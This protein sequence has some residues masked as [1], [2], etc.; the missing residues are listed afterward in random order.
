M[1]WI[2]KRMRKNLNRTAF[3]VLVILLPFLGACVKLAL[4]LTP[5]FVP[6]LRETVFEECD[7][8]LAR[9]AIPA[10][11]KLMEGLLKNDPRNRELLVTL[12]MGF[13]GYAML[14]VEGEDQERA[15]L[16]YRRARDYGIRALGEKGEA[17]RNPEAPAKEVD[18]RLNTMGR[19]DLQ[20]LFWTTLSWNAWL[21]LNLDKPAALAQQGTPEACLKRILMIDPAYMHG[22]PYVLMGV[23]LA[24][25]PPLLG[26]DM[27]QAR[28]YFEAALALSQ[29]KFLLVHYYFARYYAV[30]AQDKALFLR[31]IREI[32]DGDP[33][34][35]GDVCL[36]NKVIQERTRN[37]KD[38]LEELFF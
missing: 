34:A 30:R 8:H 12:S 19:E 13:S 38:K 32:L 27:K 37:L 3:L 35:L 10:N 5:S 22:L 28:A 4:R 7:Q 17:L 18:S 23:S 1:K 36:I 14:F 31:L 6:H 29:R 20:A 11:L 15:S 26:G 9:Q 2:R 21:N 24:A 33:H 25:R 16:F